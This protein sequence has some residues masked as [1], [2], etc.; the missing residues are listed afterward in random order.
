MQSTGYFCQIL[1]KLEFSRQIFDKYSSIEF[2]EN[3]SIGS[4]VVSCGRTDRHDEAVSHF[5]RFC[6]RAYKECIPAFQAVLHQQVT[7]HTM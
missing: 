5:P 6:E 4:G 7:E 1:M 2:H 3:P